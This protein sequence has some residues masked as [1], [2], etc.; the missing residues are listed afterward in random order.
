MSLIIQGGLLLGSNTLF[1][2]YLLNGQPDKAGEV[3][4]TLSSD[5][6]ESPFLPFTAALLQ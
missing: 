5:Y 2:L 6:P 1:R 4:K 3:Q